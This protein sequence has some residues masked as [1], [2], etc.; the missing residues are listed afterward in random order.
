MTSR[1]Q[2]MGLVVNGPLK[3]AIRRA[4]IA[5][6]VIHLQEWRLT[7]SEEL[8]RPEEERSMPALDDGLRPLCTA[9]EETFTTDPFKAGLQRTFEKVGLVP[10]QSGLHAQYTGDQHCAAVAACLMPMSWLDDDHLILGD[11]APLSC[12]ST[13]EGD[14]PRTTSK[15]AWLKTPRHHRHSLP[16]RADVEGGRGGGRL[17]Q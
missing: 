8:R 6:L 11:I 16:L 5:A 14:K 15:T 4:R 3:A 2:V 1:L 7:W 10:E 9:C 12:R 17:S 13:G